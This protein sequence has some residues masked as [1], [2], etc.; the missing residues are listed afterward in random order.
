MDEE[1]SRIESFIRNAT[2]TAFRLRALT[3]IGGGTIHRSVRA[4]GD[5]RSYF[6]KLGTTDTAA[7]F[8]AEADGLLALR[9]TR[10]FRVPEPIGQGADDAGACLILEYL[11]L[12]PLTERE[13]ARAAGA[14][15][16]NLHAHT[17]MAY[18]WHRNNYLGLTPQDNTPDDHWPTFLCVRRFEPMIR[19]ALALGFDELAAPGQALLERIPALM[20]GHRPPAALLHGD[21]WHGNIGTLPNGDAA[22]FDPAVSRG[23]PEFDLA[24]ATLF[25][26][27]P[28]SFFAAYRH[29]APPLAGAQNRAMLYSLYH[30][31]NHLVLFGRSYLRASLRTMAQLNA[32]T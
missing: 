16:A 18:G 31:L 3:P 20:V 7:M 13:Q 5:T 2:G 9:D 26:G 19:R 6:V 32:F 27:L 24:M 14:R 29:A 12:R 22:L 28:D 8:A 11:D 25:G 30:L 4:Q 17:G 1:P 21:L 23:D 15:L 10:T